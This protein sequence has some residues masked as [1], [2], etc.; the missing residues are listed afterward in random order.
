MA[1][2]IDMCSAA[3]EWILRQLDSQILSECW[4]KATILLP[5]LPPQSAILAVPM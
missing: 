2:H 4:S 3:G 1:P 5:S